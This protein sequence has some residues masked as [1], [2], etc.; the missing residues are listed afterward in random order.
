[1]TGLYQS[2]Y[3]VSFL[4]DFANP[5]TALEKSHLADDLRQDVALSGAHRPPRGLAPPAYEDSVSPHCIVPSNNLLSE[6]NN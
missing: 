6:D 5:Q 4:Y 1:M 2:D 3:L